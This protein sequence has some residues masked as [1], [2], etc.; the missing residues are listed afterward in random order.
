MGGGSPGTPPGITG[1][2]QRWGVRRSRSGDGQIAGVLERLAGKWGTVR[3]KKTRQIKNLEPRSDSIGTEKALG[4][5]QRLVFA[6]LPSRW[7]WTEDEARKRARAKERRADHDRDELQT[8]VKNNRAENEPA[9]RD[10]K[11]VAEP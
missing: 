2:K 6:L 1:R 9:C 11:E 10:R 5:Q 3:V 4:R 8:G 7:A